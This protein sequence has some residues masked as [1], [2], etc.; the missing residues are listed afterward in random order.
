MRV[1]C[2]FTNSSSSIAMAAAAF[3]VV[4]CATVADPKAVEARVRSDAAS[5]SASYCAK[6]TEGCEITVR[7]SDDGGWTASID[8]ISR[9]S[10]G[11]RVHG[12]DLDDLYMYRSN[13]SFESAL[14]NYR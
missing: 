5:R 1:R 3:L 12:I 14:R 11:R 4:S 9:A 10:D 6:Y 8:P 7:R 2:G 13:G